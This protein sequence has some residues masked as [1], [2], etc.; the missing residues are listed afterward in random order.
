MQKRKSKKKAVMKR[1][2]RITGILIVVICCVLILLLT[3]KQNTIK[4]VKVQW[5]N[6]TGQFVTYTDED[7]IRASRIMMGAQMNALYEMQD[8]AKAGIDALGY[9][10][11]EGV[12]RVN[13]DTIRICVS[14]REPIALLDASGN[15][16]LI[17]EDGYVLSHLSSIPTYNVVY[18]T[19]AELMSHRDGE[20]LVT[21]RS[22]Q[23]DDILAITNAIRKLGYEKTYSEL[24]VKDS[25]G[26]YLITNT[27]LIVQFYE[28]KDIEKTLMLANGMIV[29]KGYTTGKVIISG[30]YA[31]YQ[32]TGGNE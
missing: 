32:P 26:F 21:R 27:N 25:N 8:E 15:L 18:V 13:R 9:V 31:S 10:K 6:R 22:E 12:E 24:N 4:N 14:E 19:G 7:I 2:A 28:T 30:N 5:E 11:F 20:K 1:N 17:D 23:L 3:G 29:D 16:V